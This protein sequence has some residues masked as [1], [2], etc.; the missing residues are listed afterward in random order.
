VRRREPMDPEVKKR[1]DKMF[2]KLWLDYDEEEG[3]VQKDKFK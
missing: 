2:G 1:V 3:Y